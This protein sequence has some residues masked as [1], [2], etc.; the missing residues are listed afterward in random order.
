MKYLI[1]SLMLFAVVTVAAVPIDSGLFDSTSPVLL[2]TG[3]WTET[4]FTY[5]IG[6]SALST[7]AGSLTFDMY[8][9]GFT[10]FFLYNPAGGDVDVCVDMD[11]VSIDTAGGE[12]R[13]RLDMSGYD[14]G[15]KTVTVTPTGGTFYFDAV[16]IWHDEPMNP[17]TSGIEQEFSYG[18][19][20]HTGFFAF[21]FTTGELV[22]ILLLTFM[23]VLQIADFVRGMIHE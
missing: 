10:L 6:A 19:E 23:A 17:M 21:S 2:R 18:G 15:F 5:A 7:T 11:C 4:D 12:S 22:I 1:L 14:S 13:G 9:T 3:V 20:T 8:T 16:Y